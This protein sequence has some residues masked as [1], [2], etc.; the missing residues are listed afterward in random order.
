MTGEHG[1][2]GPV[3]L[4]THGLGFSRSALWNP[5]APEL[6]G[7]ALESGEGRLAEGGSLAV[8]TRRTGRSPIDQFVVKEAGSEEGCGRAR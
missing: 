7:F 2:R 3:G 8:E 4:E 6:Y 1:R 5:T